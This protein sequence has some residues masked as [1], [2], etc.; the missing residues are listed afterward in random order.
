MEFEL[1]ILLINSLWEDFSKFWG[2]RWN[3][4]EL[5]RSV[6]FG[7]FLREICPILIKFFPNLGWDYLI[8]PI[9]YFAGILT[10]GAEDFDDASEIYEAIGEMLVE[11]SSEGTSDEDVR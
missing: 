2:L 5:C 1:I 4:D 9:N 8:T 6:W 11:I 10:V 7:S 3:F